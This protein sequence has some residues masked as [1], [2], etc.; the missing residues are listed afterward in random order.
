MFISDLNKKEYV[1]N[2]NFLEFID[3]EDDYDDDFD[4]DYINDNIKSLNESINYLLESNN[5]KEEISNVKYNA[6]NLLNT[7][8]D[9]LDM[10]SDSLVINICAYHINTIND[11]PFLQFFLQKKN[12]NNEEIFDF[13]KF[14]YISQENA[15]SKSIS[16]MNILC[17]SYYK[18][19]KYEYNGYLYYEKNIYLF[20]DCSN[21]NIE[22]VKLNRNNEL[23]LVLLDEILN[24]KNVCNFKVSDE[25]INFFM[26]N[27]DFIYLQDKENNNLELPIVAYSSCSKNK[28]DFTLTF[29]VITENNNELMGNYYYFTDY[30]NSIKN[31]NDCLIRLAIFLR[32]MKVVLNNVDDNH[33]ES[34]ITRN[35]LLE[36]DILS[37]EYKDIKLN[38]RISDRDGLWSDNYDSVYIGKIKLDDDSYFN[39]GP[40]WVIKN[41]QQQVPLS[42][43]LINKSN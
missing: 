3:N 13:P 1:F 38:M 24:H 5:I 28:I 18:N 41:Y 2:N 37:K 20:F 7:S 17:I 11:A 19:I 10:N 15:I 4:D 8:D 25:V 29:G 40:L 21:L 39:R 16:L 26:N 32:K 43:H 30:Q 35:M 33:D 14:K 9:F 27:N 34:V 6:L 12:E 22:S 42:G 36:Y 23:W 31:E